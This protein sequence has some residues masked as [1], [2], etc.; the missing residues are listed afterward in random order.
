MK[1]KRGREGRGREG[2]DWGVEGGGLEDG[3][4]ERDAEYDDDDGGRS[5]L[6]LEWKQKNIE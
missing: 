3:G 2:G 1:R 5:I 6:L 4:T